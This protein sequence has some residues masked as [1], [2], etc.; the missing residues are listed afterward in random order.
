M[1]RNEKYPLIWRRHGD[2]DGGHVPPCGTHT[3][4][5]LG[6]TNKPVA[7]PSPVIKKLRGPRLSVTQHR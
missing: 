7:Q 5:P 4:P 1:D 3:H 2:G 6:K